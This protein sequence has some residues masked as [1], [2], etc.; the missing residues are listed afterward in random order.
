MTAYS[1]TGKKPR[2]GL[3]VPLDLLTAE[4]ARAKHPD[5]QRD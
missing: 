3:G 5:D 2:N 1:K 4:A